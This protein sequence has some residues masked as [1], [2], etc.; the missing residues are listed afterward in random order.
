MLEM[1]TVGSACMTA[2]QDRRASS[3]RPDIAK[4]AMVAWARE[5]RAPLVLQVHDSLVVETSSDQALAVG[6][7]LARVMTSAASLAVP[8]E[9]EIKRGESLAEV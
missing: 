5:G 6:E 1:L 2:A 8:L 9:V 4:L 3:I 7:E